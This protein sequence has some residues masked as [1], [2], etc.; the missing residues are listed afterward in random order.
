ME[1]MKMDDD[2]GLDGSDEDREQ[3]G[4]AERTDQ[5]NKDERWAST[6]GLKA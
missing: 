5:I 6:N 1:V 2:D 4:E 3:G